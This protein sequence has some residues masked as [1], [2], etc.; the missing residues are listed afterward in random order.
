MGVSL[1]IRRVHLYLALFLTPWMLMYAISTI[2]MN[3]RGWFESYYGGRV[4]R[5][6][7]VSKEKF[8]PALTPDASRQDVADAILAHL[9]IEGEH[10]VRGRLTQRLS[11]TRDNPFDMRR[12]TY[13]PSDSLLVVEKRR[14][15]L[16]AIL[17]SLHRRRSYQSLILTEDL[18]G[19][20][21]DLT[22]LAMLF[23]AGSGLWLWWEMS[24]TRRLG[25]IALV[26]GIAL[27][28]FFLLTI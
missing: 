8:A 6:D 27:Y 7:R 1:I 28:G 2:A 11:I 15:R 17:E 14:S 22:I 3:H 5:W 12:I 25:A 13:S 20:T 21:V 18:W 4:A 24:V 9:H 10:S 19:F 16:P 23:W 26:T